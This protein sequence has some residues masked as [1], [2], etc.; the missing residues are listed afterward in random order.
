MGLQRKK[1]IRNTRYSLLGYWMGESEWEMLELG[2]FWYFKLK[3]HL[4]QL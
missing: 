1:N 4:A 3:S 2:H